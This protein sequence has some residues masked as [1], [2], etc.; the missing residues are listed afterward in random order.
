MP[1]GEKR[2]IIMKKSD[3]IREMIIL[4]KWS[5][6]G[7]SLV[8]LRLVRRMMYNTIFH[9]PHYFYCLCFWI[10]FVPVKKSVFHLIIFHC[11]ELCY[12]LLAG[13]LTSYVIPFVVLA[14]AIAS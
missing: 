11:R 2:I 4:K 10:F 1:N 7:F 3:K 6:F 5:R 13:I 14:K 9:L 8:Y 12:V